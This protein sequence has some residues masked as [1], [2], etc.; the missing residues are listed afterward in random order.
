[1]KVSFKLKEDQKYNNI[2]DYILNANLDSKEFPIAHDA[3]TLL[4]KLTNKDPEKINGVCK[5][6]NLEKME[7]SLEI[8]YAL[9]KEFRRGDYV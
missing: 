2:L 1:M 3:K 4:N 5:K 9:K 7:T 6:L 8:L